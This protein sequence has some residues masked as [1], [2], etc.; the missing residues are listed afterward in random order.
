[1]SEVN[2]FYPPTWGTQPDYLFPRYASTV[3]RAPAKPLVILPWTLSEVTGPVFG[4]DTV[5]PSDADLTA[6]HAGEPIGERIVVSGR[7]LDEN[8][9]PVRNSLVEVWQAN[10][11]GRYPHKVDNHNAPLDPNFSGA[12][13]CFTDNEGNYRFVTIRPGEYPWRNHNNAWRPA[14]IHFSLFGGSIAT[15]LVTQMYFPG[16]PLLE[17]DPMYM[18]VPD[19]KA[20]QRLVATFDWATTIPEQA[21]GYRWD[22]VLRGRHQT[23]MEK[24]PKL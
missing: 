24:M 6:Q 23:P 12:G 13:R 22:I 5:K 1:V 15:R 20:R 19:E 11:A 14:H 18:C 4:H 3:K 7:V 9:R 8:G 17:Y 21:L 10:A 2:G 16:D